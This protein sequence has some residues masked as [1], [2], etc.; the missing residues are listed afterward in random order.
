MA[1]NYVQLE[2]GEPVEEPPS[3][4]DDDKPL[5]VYVS[6]A[7]PA[8]LRMRSGPSTDSEVLKVLPM[9][10]KLTVLE[11]TKEVIGDY[12]KWLK[13]RDPEGDEGYVAAWYVHQ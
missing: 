10:T 3:E 13:V 11:G 2:A 7:A 4:P 8:G 12:G 1:A 6:S 9:G 5:T